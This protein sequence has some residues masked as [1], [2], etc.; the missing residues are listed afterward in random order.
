MRAAYLLIFIL[1]NG[2]S[3]GDLFDILNPTSN[4]SN[5]GLIS[6]GPSPTSSGIVSRIDD[7]IDDGIDAFRNIASSAL[8]PFIGIAGALTSTAESLHLPGADIFRDILAGNS[9]D[10]FSAIARN[11]ISF[12][13][14][15]IASF[16][17]GLQSGARQLSTLI[18]SLLNGD[19]I[20]SL[21][22]SIRSI[23]DNGFRLA[24]SAI[25]RVVSSLPGIGDIASRIFNGTSSGSDV[26]RRVISQATNDGMI[27][28]SELVGFIDMAIDN[29]DN[30]TAATLGNLRAA[31]TGGGT[32]ISDI[33]GRAIYSVPGASSGNISISGLR[34]AIQSEIANGGSEVARAL[35]P[36]RAA[37]SD[38]DSRVSDFF[39]GVIS[40]VRDA[41]SEL[42]QFISPIFNNRALL[43]LLGPL[44]SI[45]RFGLSAV[46]TPIWNG[47]Y[48]LLSSGGSL[49][50]GGIWTI[51]RSVLTLAIKIVL[52]IIRVAFVPI[53][54]FGNFANQGTSPLGSI[55]STL[56]NG[57]QD[58]TNT[59]N[60][61]LRAFN[62]LNI[63]GNGIAPN[64]SNNP[65]NLFGSQIANNNPL[66]AIGSQIANNNPLNAI[67]S[68]IANNNPFN[69]VG[70][71]IA[72]NNPLTGL[73][74]LNGTNPLG[75]MAS[76]MANNN[77]TGLSPL[78]G[79]NPLGAMTS[80]IANN[81]PLTG[82]FPPNGTNPLGSMASQIANNNPLTGLFPPN[83]TNQL[84]AMASQM[85]NNN[86]LTGIFSPNGT[87]PLGAMASQLANN[88]PFTGISPFNGNNPIGSI[89]SQIANNNPFTGMFPVNNTNPLGAIASQIANHN[90]LMG[91]FTP[92]LTNPFGSIG[93]QIANLNPLT[94]IFPPNGTNPLTGIFPPNGTN[95]LTGIFPPN[96][97]NPLGSIA[98]QIASNNP[99]MG[100]LPLN[101]TNPLTGIFPPNGINP[102]AGIFP[103][104]GMN[105]LGSIASQIANNPLMGLFPP[106]GPSDGNN[107]SGGIFPSGTNN[108]L[109]A[110]FPIAENNPLS[111]ISRNI[112]FGPLQDYIRS[113]LLNRVNF[114]SASLAALRSRFGDSILPLLAPFSSIPGASN[115]ASDIFR[116][117][118]MSS[119]TSNS[120]I[121]STLMGPFFSRLAEVQN[122]APFGNIIEAV[123]RPFQQAFT[124]GVNGTPNPIGFALAPILGVWNGASEFLRSTGSPFGNITDAIIRPFQL[125][126]NSGVNG[127]P[128]PIGL[129]VAP[130]LGVWNGASE[131]LRSTGSPFGNI[132]DAIIRP[133]QSALNPGVN[134]T[135]NA[136]ELL[137]APITGA[138]NGASQLLRSTGSPLGN[139]IDAIIRPFQTALN[140]GING[141]PNPIGLVFAP[142]LGASN[143]ITEFLRSTGSPFG[144][145]IEGIIR[146]FQSALNSGVNGTPNLVGLASAPILGVWN[147]ASEFLRSTGSP[148]GN[149]IDAFLRPFQSA[150]NPGVN[151]TPNPIELVSAPILG[152]WNGTSQ[153]LSSS[154]SPFGNVIEGIIR[155]FQSALNSGVNGIPNFIGL[156]SAPILGV[157]NGAS[158]F[159]RSTGSP[160]GNAIEAILRPF[161][162]ALNSGVDGTPNFVGLAS[163]PITG[164]LNGA[165]A[166]LR[167]IG[168]PYGNVFEAVVRPFESALN[169]GGNGVPNPIGLA[170]APVSGAWNGTIELL[171]SNGLAFSNVIE[172]IM[173]PFQSALNSGLN[174]IP[175]PIGLTSAPILGAWN[176][177]TEFLRTIGLPFG[178]IIQAVTRPFQSALNSGVFGSPNPIGLASAPILGV[179]NGASEFLRT[180]GS[181]FGNIIQSVIGPLQSALNSGINGIPNPIGLTSAPILGLWN[182][183][184][185]FL[186]STGSPFGNIIQALIEPFQSALN[187]GMNGTPNPIGLFSAP[188][189]GV[190]NGV[191]EFLR[192]TGSPFGNII[193][194]VI[195]PFQAALNSGMNGIPNPIG[196]TSAPILG[197]WNGT[198]QFLRSTGS[199]F[200]NII[201]AVIGPFQSALNSGIN[202]TTNPIGLVSAPILGVLNGASEFLR[203][204]G[205]PFGNI[206]QAVIRPIQSALSSGINETT[207]P[208]R[209][210]S[211]PILGVLNG[212]SEF[213]RTT[214]SPFGNIVQAMIEPFQSALN[215]GMNGTPDPVGLASAPILGVWNGFSELLRSTG[216]PFGNVIQA[217]LRQFRSALNPGGNATQN[218]SGPDSPPLT[219]A[220]NGVSDFLRS[221]SDFIETAMRPFG[222]GANGTLDAFRMALAPILGASNG[223][224]NGLPFSNVIDAIF[225]PIQLALNS[226]V[227]GTPDP[228]RLVMAPL[229]GA[230]NGATELLR[231]SGSPFGNGMGALMRPNLVA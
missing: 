41:L 95:P 212:A 160:F 74:T 10:P 117:V 9:T 162:S 80:Q 189:L 110:F 179:L 190:L 53:K 19:D 111:I 176:G 103:P 180:T 137:L 34:S 84:G 201:Q 60:N 88:N 174:G 156:V 75:S 52:G 108:P 140:S 45:I 170:L 32:A 106:N 136:F 135:P 222:S 35:G 78:N 47:I 55:G 58:A 145:V 208:I 37:L 202:G 193:Q 36:L 121:H 50:I 147:G 68:Q 61:A 26:I 188:I 70:S 27:S 6:S 191:S 214:G 42:W 130:I 229:S 49:I 79:T 82:L 46:L 81:N 101:G 33:I 65:L 56:N 123:L 5:G 16:I 223:S 104:N 93:S 187:S 182:G 138:W 30:T 90:P 67:G 62:P 217:M 105:P 161:Q 134:A 142:I 197:L 143:G 199:P 203:T 185:Q 31:L 13:S 87:N 73:V 63:I 38:E 169:S 2:S 57:F 113:D 165:S 92:N 230:W 220:S 198:S 186:R 25:E 211:A 172:E 167:S 175:N 24:A 77:L 226:G 44:G 109:N 163:A 157:L 178:N 219:G 15:S 54:G 159:L 132:T 83:G 20:S 11:V 115:V 98:S 23:F 154:G 164:V 86:P 150:L 225:R 141:T 124:S 71:Q 96:G 28:L 192:T 17:P 14:S 18:Q 97:I 153:F 116:L 216:S 1:V 3:A 89:A 133:F 127:T 224:S 195:E 166:F 228:F 40:L 221:S 205:S 7:A 122:R 148:F 118:N 69:A 218:P 100:I 204:T 158:E 4:D 125:A 231:S 173:R 146:P 139:V 181:P 184:S 129:A 155:P 152:L 209:L 12:F 227:N 102:L 171:R 196:L 43:I 131:F 206:I 151:G 94:G 207:N 194:A 64:F 59:V 85:A 112:G 177:A 210:V 91:V 99:L 119:D 168:S 29:G 120:S 107:P 144:N 76:Q 21:L 114:I 39:G 8:S 200:G 51:L 126:L 66:N 213:L 149:A 48:G 183:T 215:S 72:N 128:N 22:G